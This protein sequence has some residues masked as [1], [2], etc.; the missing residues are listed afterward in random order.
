[1]A[2]RRAPDSPKKSAKPVP[3]AAAPKVRKRRTGAAGV[4]TVSEDERRGMIAYSAYLRGERRG[5]APGGEAQ[6]WLLAEQ[7]V[8]ALLNSGHTPTQ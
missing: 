5:F 2:I 6:D 1:M 3:E 8:D 4:P 7:E